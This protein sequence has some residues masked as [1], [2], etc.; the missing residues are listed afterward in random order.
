MKHSGEGRLIE[1]GARRA[2]IVRPSCLSCCVMLS[3]LAGER[4]SFQLAE[5]LVHAMSE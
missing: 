5:L 2:Y 3:C 4:L 1:G